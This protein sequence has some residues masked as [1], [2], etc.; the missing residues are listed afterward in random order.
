MKEHKLTITGLVISIA[1][2]VTTFITEIDFFEII[3]TELESLE[4]YEIDEFIIP[5]VIFVIFLLSDLLTKQR[6]QKIENEKVKIYKA[7]LSS[8]HHILNNFLNKMQLFKISVENTEKLPTEALNL[9]DQII[10]DTVNQID[11][12]GNIITID[13]E[14]ILESVSPNS[15]A[16]NTSEIM[17]KAE[18]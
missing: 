12:V 2:L 6:N 13:E 15:H 7:M 3:V 5:V 8:T 9:Y 17:C 14:S 1:V 18:S 11:T 4:A 16:H 10:K